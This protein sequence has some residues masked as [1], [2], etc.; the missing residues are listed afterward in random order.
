[1][2]TPEYKTPEELQE[3]I[4]RYFKE[5]ATIRKVIVGSGKSAQVVELPILTI[6]GLCFYLGFESRQ[7]FYDYE[8]RPSYSYTI[9][10]ARL[11]MEKEYE[12]MLSAGNTTGAIFALKNFGWT[13][14]TELEHSGEVK[15][16]VTVSVVSANNTIPESE[17]DVEGQ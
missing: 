4:E 11:F 7:S 12:E 13:D 6:T 9:K 17:E 1:M 10:R 14:K 3:A 15:S 16:G 8:K 5:G 2:R